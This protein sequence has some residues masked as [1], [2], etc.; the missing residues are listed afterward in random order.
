MDTSKRKLLFFY[1]NLMH[2]NLKYTTFLQLY[3]LD[4]YNL[5][6]HK[7]RH[8]SRIVKTHRR[9]HSHFTSVSLTVDIENTV[10]YTVIQ[11]Y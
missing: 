6:L 10:V 4:T 3:F 2:I 9:I 7:L 8:P 11:T 1:L 5:K